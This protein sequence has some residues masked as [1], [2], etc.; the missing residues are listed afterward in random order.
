MKTAAQLT[1]SIAALKTDNT[2]VKCALLIDELEHALINGEDGLIVDSGSPL[3]DYFKN[4]N[5][6]RAA[7]LALLKS[8]GYV[9][10]RH[11]G[12]FYFRLDALSSAQYP[13]IITL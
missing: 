13:G 12:I 7:M 11:N 8:L 4:T 1:A 9:I 6:N 3:S 2:N 5:V 10:Q